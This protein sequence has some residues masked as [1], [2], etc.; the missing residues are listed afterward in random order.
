[1]DIVSAYEVELTD[2]ESGLS[3]HCMAVPGQA[4]AEYGP[5]EHW[6]DYLPVERLE[7]VGLPSDLSVALAAILLEHEDAQQAAA[8]YRELHDPERWLAA[9]EGFRERLGPVLDFVEYAAYSPV[10]PLEQ[11]PLDLHS[12]GSL[13]AGSSQVGGGAVL[14]IVVAGGASPLLFITVPAGII[15]VGVAAAFT[16]GLRYHIRRLMRVP[17]EPVPQ[18]VE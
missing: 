7:Q 11:S 16:E 2:R 6:L 14:G 18:E 1:V 17:D 10:V 4:L 3:L 12:L 15:V 13:L 5:P 9:W 8:V